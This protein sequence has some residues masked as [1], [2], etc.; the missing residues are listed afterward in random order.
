LLGDT[1]KVKK[2]R[3]ERYEDAN[4]I[5]IYKVSPTSR[6]TLDYKQLPLRECALPALIFLFP[7]PSA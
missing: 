7:I 4:V 3:V 6:Q 2:H 5:S 1:I